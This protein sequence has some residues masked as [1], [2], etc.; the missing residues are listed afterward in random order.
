MNF[1]DYIPNL[2]SIKDN[3]KIY[4]KLMF[5]KTLA[6]QTRKM[7]SAVSFQLFG[8]FCSTWLSASYLKSDLSA[9]LI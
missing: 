3:L 1:P 8:L 2:T 7:L 6:K 9:L 4:N 5:F